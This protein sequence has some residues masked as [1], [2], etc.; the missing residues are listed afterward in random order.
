MTAG[1]TLRLRS[2]GFDHWANCCN[3][4]FL[5]SPRG[6]PVRIDCTRSLR[7]ILLR[8]I[9]AGECSGHLTSVFQRQTT[10]AWRVKSKTGPVHGLAKNIRR[11]AMICL[12]H[13]GRE[14]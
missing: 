8:N 2:A 7:K 12:G 14:C 11:N 4:F 5:M 10:A 13:G 6:R 1:R 3:T 9:R